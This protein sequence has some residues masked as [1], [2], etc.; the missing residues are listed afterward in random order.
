MRL[1]LLLLLVSALNALTLA[2]VHEYWFNKNNPKIAGN[3]N[4]WYYC[5]RKCLYF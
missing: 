5:G 1:L 3:A 2:P 4:Q